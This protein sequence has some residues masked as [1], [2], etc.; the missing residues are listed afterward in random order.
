M[1][2]VTVCVIVDVSSLESPSSEATRT[3]TVWGVIQLM[4]VNWRAD[5]PSV[6]PQSE[7]F[8]TAGVTRTVPDG[9]EAS[10]TV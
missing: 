6:T 1:A 9:C 7:Q 4:V 10:A 5:V 8:V 3:V 2:P